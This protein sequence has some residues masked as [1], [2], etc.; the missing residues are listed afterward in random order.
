MSTRITRKLCP[1]LLVLAVAGCLSMTGG[2]CMP[3][4]P[5][6]QQPEVEL[7]AGTLAVMPFATPGATYFESKIGARFSRNIADVVAEALPRAKVLDVD[8]IRERLEPPQGSSFSI[9]KLGER[10]KADYMLYGEI[11]RLAGK[12]PR[13]YGVLQGTM[14]VTARVIDVRN[15][16]EV[17]LAERKTYRYPPL[18]MGKEEA[19]ADETEIEIVIRK[20]MEA[21]AEGI[22]AV[23]T[24]RER[25]LGERIDRVIK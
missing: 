15:R 10:L 21:A 25:P 3:D 8:G 16:R 5:G 7:G 22:A 11:H 2:D 24:G 18:L 23:F 20:T 9:V 4:N 17:W 14:V 1:A 12:P 6:V 19:P 13:S